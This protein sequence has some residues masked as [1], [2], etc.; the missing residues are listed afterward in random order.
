MITL[1]HKP[2]R[3]SPPNTSMMCSSRT[4]VPL[5]IQ[6]H[7]QPKKD[8]LFHLKGTAPPFATV[9]IYNPEIPEWPLLGSVNCDPGGRY[10]FQFYDPERFQYGDRLVINTQ[11][12]HVDHHTIHTTLLPSF[13]VTREQARRPFIDLS[14]VEVVYF[15]DTP[16][17]LSCV[18]TGGPKSVPPKIQI[19]LGP[20]STQANEDG[21]FFLQMN[22]LQT[23]EYYALFL[24]NHN[25]AI[26]TSPFNT[27]EKAHRLPPFSLEDPHMCKW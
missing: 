21:S 11:S 6:H 10:C 19:S 14:R 8:T 18:F 9:H 1:F 16:D 24:R 5:R 27:P 23:D 22:A 15:P 25:N 26:A 2:K 17:H 13:E 20:F 7:L 3:S 4:P 12:E